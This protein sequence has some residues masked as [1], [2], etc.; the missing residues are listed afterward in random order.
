MN[1]ILKHYIKIGLSIS[2]L[3][4]SVH[5][6]ASWDCHSSRGG[7]RTTNSDSW[8]GTDKLEHFSVSVPFGAIG[9]Y[10]TRDTEHPVVY[11]TMI[12]IVPGIAK[13]VFDGTCK[14]DGFSYKDL[15]ADLLGSFTGAML[16]NYAINYYRDKHGSTIGVSYQK[17][18]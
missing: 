6:L 7:W 18:F 15:T 14:T 3:T 4:S 5:A 8:T 13:E 9:A 2:L 11:G 10:L 12:G 17:T 16:G 1:N